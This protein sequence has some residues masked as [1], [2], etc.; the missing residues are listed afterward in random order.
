MK[1]GSTKRAVL[2]GERQRERAGEG[3]E[4]LLFLRSTSRTVS[5]PLL[6][7]S[8]SVSSPSDF[9]RY[10][11]ANLTTLTFLLPLLRFDLPLRT[12]LLPLSPFTFSLLLPSRP[13]P[14]PFPLSTL[15]YS[16]SISA[17]A[18]SSTFLASHLR[19]P[20]FCFPSLAPYIAVIPRSFAHRQLSPVF[21]SR[22]SF[23]FLRHS[24]YHISALKRT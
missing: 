8:L 5:S 16:Y 10:Y 17:C 20:S 21:R 1:E 6:P 3:Y 15:L 22:L 9:P 4:T 19:P 24:A 13:P 12:P 7:P 14:D 18:P 2:E 11:P 23:S